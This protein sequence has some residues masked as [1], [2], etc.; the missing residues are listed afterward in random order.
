MYYGFN[1][2]LVFPNVIKHTQAGNQGMVPEKALFTWKN[3]QHKQ[4]NFIFFS[5]T[6]IVSEGLFFIKVQHLV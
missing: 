4:N 2:P 3:I 6:H 5:S 1:N